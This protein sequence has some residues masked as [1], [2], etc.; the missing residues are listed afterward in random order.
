MIGFLH[1]TQ[2]LTIRDDRGRRFPIRSPHLRLEMKADETMLLWYRLAQVRR[3]RESTATQVVGWGVVL[4]ACALLTFACVR[5]AMAGNTQRA[6]FL[7]VFLPPVI[8]LGYIWRQ[9]MDAALEKL[10]TA[11]AKL[12]PVCP[13]CRYHLAGLPTEPD[14]CTVCPECG[15]AWRFGPAKS[16]NGA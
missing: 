10:E 15:A 9:Q 3:D 5:A 12:P 7:F 1:R 4:I 14:G 2:T 11:R 16:A 6:V 13:S 8:A